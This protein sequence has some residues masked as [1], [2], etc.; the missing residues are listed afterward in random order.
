MNIKMTLN[1]AKNAS[2]I[3]KNRTVIRLRNL[4]QWSAWISGKAACVTYEY[5]TMIIAMIA[6]T[7]ILS[8]Q[9][10]TMILNATISKGMSKAMFRKKFHPIA[11]DKASSYKSV[12]F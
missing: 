2:D 11:K 5:A 4:N 8:V 3:P 7:G 1:V 10:V 6:S 9:K 12:R